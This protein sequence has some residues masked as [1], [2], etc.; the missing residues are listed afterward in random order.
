LNAIAQAGGTTQA[1]LVESSGEA[2]LLA[3][4]EAIRTSALTCEYALPLTPANTPRLD[5]VQVSTRRSA[6]PAPTAVDQVASA[7]ACAGGP[8]WFFNNAVSGGAL[9]SKITLCP[10]SCSPLLQGTRNALEVAF[11]CPPPPR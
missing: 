11:G 6:D 7:E 8:G 9:P 5:I 1:Y 3:A 10:A 2:S 4:L